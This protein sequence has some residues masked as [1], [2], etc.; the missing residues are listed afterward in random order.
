MIFQF[1]QYEIDTDLFELKHA[2]EPVAIEPLAF[3][4]LV[5]L[6][7]HRDRV[8]TRTELLEQLW[9]G[10]VVTDAAL[11]VRLKDVRKAVGDTGNQQRLIKTLH[12]RGY[13]FV[14]DVTVVDSDATADIALGPSTRTLPELP[15]K[16]SIAVLPFLNLSNDQDQEYFSDGISEDII[17]ALTYF[18]GLFVISRNSSF[19]YK[20]QHIN[21]KSVAQQLGVRYLLEGSVRRSADRIRISAQLV[22]A[23]SENQ[24]WAEKFDGELGDIFT[25]QDEITRKIVSSIGP[26]I[27]LAEVERGRKLH[28][29][30]LSSYELALKAKSLIYDAYREGDLDGLADATQFA[31]EALQ[32]DEL[33]THALWILSVVWADL[34]LYQWGREPASSLDIA[35]QSAERLIKVDSGDARG[36]TTRGCC[37]IL[38]HDFELGLADFDRSLELNPNSALNLFWCAWGESLA[39]QTQ[40]AIDHAELGLRLSPREMDVFLGVAYLS[41]QQAYFAESDFDNAMQAGQKSIQMQSRAPIRRAL[42]IASCGFVGDLRQAQMHAETLAAFSPGFVDSI[43]NGE[44]VLYRLP[45]HNQ[46]VQQGLELAGAKTA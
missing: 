21:T 10:K 17:T 4:L 13:Q 39:G 7:R 18:P 16:P 26:Q 8:V 37:H 2:D 6:L 43:L 46:L 42:M 38:R 19:S 41:L 27:E 5:Y 34:Y 15:D 9:P 14:G 40:K 23:R 36:Y 29:A 24:I 11:G 20:G 35:M 44:L 30:S 1:L 3:D 28:P 45:A 33:N 12:R 31:E 22:N 25:L 32:L